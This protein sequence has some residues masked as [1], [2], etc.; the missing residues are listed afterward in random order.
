MLVNAPL[1]E[2]ALLCVPSVYRVASRLVII[3]L[4]VCYQRHTKFYLTF[5]LEFN[6]ALRKCKCKNEI[7]GMLVSIQFRNDRCLRRSMWGNYWTE[8]VGSTRR[9]YRIA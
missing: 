2:S 6:Y 3:K 1:Y 5:F 8:E 7:Q 9:L 4:Y